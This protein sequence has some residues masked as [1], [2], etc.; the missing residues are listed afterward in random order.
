MNVGQAVT[1]TICAVCLAESVIICYLI[2]SILELHDRQREDNEHW[3]QKLVAIK[4]PV[5]LSLLGGNGPE[6]KPVHYV[7]ETREVEL[8]GR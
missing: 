5:A 7:D 1:L 2:W 8:Q 4:A 6:P 3:A